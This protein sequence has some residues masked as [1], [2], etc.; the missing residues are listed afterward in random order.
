MGKS[1][2]VYG[3]ILRVESG[4]GRLS[5][6]GATG[7]LE[8]DQRYFIA[9]VTKMYVTVVVLRLCRENRMSL[10]DPIADRLPADLIQGIHVTDGVDRT[11]E[12]TIRHLISNTSGITDYFFGKDADGKKA[13]SDLFDGNDE[14]WPLERILERVRSL[15]PRFAPGQ[16]G[17]VHYSDTNYE[18]LG[19]IIET[20][21]GKS[22]AEVF[23][24]FIFD[25]LG[26]HD[27]YAY[28]DPTDTSPAPMYYKDK[29]VHVPLYIASITPEGGIVS[30]AKE[31][32]I[33][34][35]A[36][37]TGRF[38]PP[39]TVEDLKRWNRI[40]FP[41]QFDYGIGLERQ[42]IPRIM[43]PFT[44]IGELLGF[45]GQCGAF[46]FHNPKRDLY[47]TGTVNQLSGFGHG[48]AVSAMVRVMKSVG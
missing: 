10:D 42:W 6:Q 23:A 47:F 44:P 45:W 13:A 27:T 29:P 48:A 26:L 24:E 32:M 25:E 12:I 41:G 28:T 46:A 19:R 35:K 3:A 43:T 21:T 18:L 37:F 2:A 40:F 22:C 30:T 11:G 15:K 33:F 7:N 20:V 39:E 4:D 34:L 1:R 8:A 5:W 36:F 9:S 16:P 31:T 38:F 14:P 17:K